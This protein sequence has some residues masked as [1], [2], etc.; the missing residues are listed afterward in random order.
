MKLLSSFLALFFCF[1]HT[2]GQVILHYS[3]TSGFDHQ[4]RGVSLAMFQGLGLANN[5]QIDDDQT[6]DSFNSLSNLEQYDLIVFSNTSGDGIL[7][8]NQRTNF[9]AYINNGG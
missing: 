3:E 2:I 4:T 6:G 5:F 8:A 1:N 9:E 7:D